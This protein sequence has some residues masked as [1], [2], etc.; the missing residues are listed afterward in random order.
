[1]PV[2]TAIIKTQSD[3]A[4][5]S[6]C[7]PS[8]DGYIVVSSFNGDLD[9]GPIQKIGGNLTIMGN[10]ELRS[11]IASKLSSIQGSLNVGNL[12]SLETL[13]MPNLTNAGNVYLSSLPKLS[14]V[15]F[16][17]ALIT[18]NVVMTDTAL[19]S[20]PDFMQTVALMEISNNTQMSSVNLSIES[21]TRLV[22]GM[23]GSNLT[24][25]MPNLTTATIVKIKGVSQ[26]DLPT[27]Q[28]VQRDM[29]V[30]DNDFER[31][32]LPSLVSIDFDLQISNNSRLEDL[33]LPLFQSIGG[34]L[35]VQGNPSLRDVPLSKLSNVGGVMNLNGTFSSL[36]IPEIASVQGDMNI[37]TTDKF[38]CDPLIDYKEKGVIKGSLSCMASNTNPST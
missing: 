15:Q 36:T 18:N 6:S 35:K 34:D 8:F 7:W 17:Q 38:S 32:S 21:A 27:L 19:T 13:S 24:A 23:N 31:L 33:S 3:A 5:L 37:W 2:G 12:T 16:K 20:P 30:S 26:L 22:V 4:L 28:S 1:C 10:Q 11:V 14:T 9:L 29:L 25:F